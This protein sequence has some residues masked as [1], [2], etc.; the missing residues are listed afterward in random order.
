[1]ISHIDGDLLKMQDEFGLKA[2]CHQVNCQG[3]MGAGIAKQIRNKYPEVYTEYT[4]ECA[5]HTA[6]YHQNTAELLGAIQVV[7][8]G[9]GKYVCNL[10]AQDR[11]GKDGRRYT[12]YDAFWICLN[13]IANLFQEGDKIGFPYGISCGLG[14]A[15]WN[16]IEAMIQEVL[17]SKFNVYIVHYKE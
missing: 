14:G 13:R 7:R 3:V 1:M 2:I 12:S 8:V 10:F 11:Y 15:N 16:I 17:G 4:A 9:E 6:K 5:K